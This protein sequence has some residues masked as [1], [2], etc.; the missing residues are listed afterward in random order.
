MTVGKYTLA[1]LVLTL[2]ALASG[3]SAL[4]AAPTGCNA[5]SSDATCDSASNPSANSGGN[6]TSNAGPNGACNHRT[7]VADVDSGLL[8]EPWFRPCMQCCQDLCERCEWCTWKADA[9]AMIMERSKPVAQ[10]VLVDANGAS[11]FQTS[12]LNF[13]DAVGPRI[14]ITALDCEGWG[15]EVNYFGIDGWSA[16]GEFPNQGNLAVGGVGTPLALNDVHFASISRLYSTECNFRV[17]LLGNLAFLAG[18]RWLEMTD[19]YSAVGTNPTTMNMASGTIL[20][21][22]HMYG[23]QVGADGALFQQADRWRLNG[24]VKGGIFLNDADQATSFNDPNGLGYGA[25]NNCHSGAAFFGEAGLTV[26]IQLSK[27]VSLSGG[28][29]VMFVNNVAQP[30]NQLG[31]TDFSVTPAVTTVDV[32]SGIFYHGA[33]VGLEVT[34]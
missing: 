32:N 28:Y 5:S 6:T 21:H 12:Q 13:N 16:A 7:C 17:P 15:F 1:A 8:D 30:A 23:F 18:F 27:H 24:F 22:N 4:G 9:S 14:S 19:S 25:A 11:L 2:L 26:Y 33:T 3:Q 34:W 29:E 31:N 10:T 20:T